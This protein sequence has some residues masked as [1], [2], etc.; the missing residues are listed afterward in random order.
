ME[1]R[2]EIENLSNRKN[3]YDDEF[4]KLK[5]KLTGKDKTFV[6]TD[7][8]VIKMLHEL[9]CHPLE[10]RVAVRIPENNMSNSVVV[11]N[12]EKIS[13]AIKEIKMYCLENGFDCYFNQEEYH[14][15]CEKGLLNKSKQ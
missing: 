11:H 14:S 13:E 3:D 8:F 4:D 7:D 1:L 12:I 2:K 15:L 6:I 9:P 5:A 10:C